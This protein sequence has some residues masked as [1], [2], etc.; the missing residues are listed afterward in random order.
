MG[1]ASGEA[2]YH[3]IPLGYLILYAGLQVGQGLPKGSSVLLGALHT[4]DLRA[5]GIVADLIRGVDLVGGGEI[6]LMIEEF[7]N[8][9]ARHSL[10][11]FC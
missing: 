10:V 5:G 8:L 4:T 1:T 2:A 7:L 11:L 6:P 9:S 3:L